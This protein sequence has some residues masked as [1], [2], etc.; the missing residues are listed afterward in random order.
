[1]LFSDRKEDMRRTRLRDAVIQ[2]LGEFR[3]Y[4]AS[5]S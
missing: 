4:K 1:M 2:D 3:N 5:Y